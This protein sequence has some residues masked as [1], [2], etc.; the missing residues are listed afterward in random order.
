M[1]EQE[2]KAASALLAMLVEANVN[3]VV[4]IVSAY[5]LLA[6]AALLRKQAEVT[7]V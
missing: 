1:N 6:Q 2:Q 5:Q 4:Q 3:E 7:K